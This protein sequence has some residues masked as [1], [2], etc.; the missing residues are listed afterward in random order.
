MEAAL[1]RAAPTTPAWA[2]V[3]PWHLLCVCRLLITVEI[4][5]HAWLHAELCPLSCVRGPLVV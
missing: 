3:R 1:S 5:L 4:L 2:L